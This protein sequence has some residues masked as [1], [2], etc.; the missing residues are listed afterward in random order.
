MS[1]AAGLSDKPQVIAKLGASYLRVMK[2]KRQQEKRKGNAIEEG[3]REIAKRGRIS[4]FSYKSRLNL[5]QTL[6]QV[7]RNN[8]PCF[9]TLTYP[10]DFTFEVERWK[11]DLMTFIKRLSRTFPEVCGI[12]KL[13]P[14]DRGAPHYHVMVWG[15]ELE[16]L[17]DFVPQAWH[18]VVGSDD[19]NHLLWHM[20][21]CG[22]GNKHCVSEVDRAKAMYK[23]VAK[24]ISKDVMEAL[25]GWE[26]VGRWW[27][28]FFRG[29]MPFG[30]EAVFDITDKK[31]V[32]L[33]RY[34]RRFAHIRAR[35]HPSLVLICDVDHWLEKLSTIPMNSFLEW[36][37]KYTSN[38]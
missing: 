1:K 31:A 15:A 28:I 27:G 7:K 30:E 2:A 16:G 37:K 35:Q 5:L 21:K 18:A 33:M 36:E 10:K 19:V 4:N 24:Y 38:R 23:Y 34:F 26:N 8:L 32:E 9:V 14:Q 3:R 29:R 20:G 12:W 13:E 6:A 22:N 17:R 11:R 25:A